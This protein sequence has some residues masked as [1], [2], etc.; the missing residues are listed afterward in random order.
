LNEIG[1]GPR[2]ADHVRCAGYSRPHSP[3]A[4]SVNL[5]CDLDGVIDFGAEVTNGILDLR[6]TE[7]ELHRY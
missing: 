2:A 5:L 6:T 1:D 7:Q 4:S 3:F